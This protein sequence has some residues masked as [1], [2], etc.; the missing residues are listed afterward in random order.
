MKDKDPIATD[1]RRR[2]R[3]RRLGTDHPTCDLCGYSGL[4]ALTPVTSGWLKAH[5]IE[6]HHVVGKN[7]DPNLVVS[8]C[9]NC[10]RTATEGLAR[11]GVS[12]RS[13]SDP[14]ARVAQML[15]A[16]AAFFEMLVDALRRWAELLWEIVATPEPAHG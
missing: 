6:R 13:E 5:G 10:H 12:M 9:L 3:Q 2:R 14:I 1:V 8:L 4:E 7:N 11:A 15:D 16:L